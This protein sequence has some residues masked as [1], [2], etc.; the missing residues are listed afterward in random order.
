MGRRLASITNPEHTTTPN[1]LLPEGNDG[2]DNGGGGGAPTGTPAPG[3]DDGKPAKPDD[4][5][6]DWKSHARTW[7]TKA[8]ADAARAEQLA[9][10][11]ERL[12]TAQMSDSEKA[13]EAARLE[14][15]Q[16][17][18]AEAV[19]EAVA[20]RLEAA[21]S[22]LP[23]TQRDA[24]IDSVSRGRF[25]DTSGKPDRAAIK[26]WAEQVAPKPDPKQTF[27]AL[28]QGQRT[29]PPTTDMNALIRRQVGF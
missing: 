23:E 5:G 29:P 2:G 8:K 9:A 1:P 4:A 27:P 16:T 18:A 24:L 22:H 6:T 26:A 25:L 17:G 20:A 3:T 15:R 21:L 11:V 13:I 7:E 10:E 12:K 19:G 28:G 14:G